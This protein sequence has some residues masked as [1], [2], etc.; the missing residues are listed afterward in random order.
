MFQHEFGH[1]L[2]SR[3]FGIFWLPTFGLASFTSSIINDYETHNRFP[4]EQDAN[5]RALRYLVKN[6]DNR[7]THI[8][9]K[10]G[11]KVSNWVFDDNPILGYDET[12][13]FND[14]VNQMAINRAIIPIIITITR[15]EKSGE[16]EIIYH[17]VIL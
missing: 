7:F 3:L 13:S 14:E 9:P 10:T 1:V 5:A 2:Q 15:K 12:K 17:K 6:S 11:D 4:T 8:D 16:D